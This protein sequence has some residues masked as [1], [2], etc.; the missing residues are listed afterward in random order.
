VLLRSSPIGVR[1]A[2]KVGDGDLRARWWLAAATALLGLVASTTFVM[3]Q[4]PVVHVDE[5]GV[6]AG[7]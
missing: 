6:H 2:L 4:T 1:L 3:T 5:I 7:P